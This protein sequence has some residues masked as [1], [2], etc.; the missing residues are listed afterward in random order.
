MTWL[1]SPS[2]NWFYLHTGLEEDIPA[3]GGFP[4]DVV[5]ISDADHEQFMQGVDSGKVVKPGSDGRPSLHDAPSTPDAVPDVVSAYQ[6]RA[7]LI[8]AGLDDEVQAAIDAIGDPV[9]RKL[10]QNAWDKAATVRRDS[11]FTQ[12]LA[13]ALGLSDAQLDNL[14]IVAAQVQ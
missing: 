1:Y 8:M 2:T 12:T 10:T 3:T 4:E 11:P 5:V 7:A 9:G 6:A 14:F 13:A